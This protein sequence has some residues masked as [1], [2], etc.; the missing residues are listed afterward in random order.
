MGLTGFVGI[1]G[2]VP[3]GLLINIQTVASVASLA[4]YDLNDENVR[5]LVLA[6]LAGESLKTMLSQFGMTTT[7]VLVKGAV[8]AIPRWLLGKI[9]A[10]VGRRLFTKFSE[11]GIIQLGKAVP[12]FGGVVGGAFDAFACNMVGKVAIDA[13]VEDACV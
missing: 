7:K 5:M 10:M 11:K 4:G 1:V 8:N 6:C 9:N 2:D 13:F 12:I 3:S